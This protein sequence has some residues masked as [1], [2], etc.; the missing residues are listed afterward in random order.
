MRRVR[1]FE[2]YRLRAVLILVALSVPACRGQV[3][4]VLDQANASAWTGGATNIALANTVSQTFVP[5]LS[6]LIAV[7]VGLKTGN[8]GQGGD[9]VTLQILNSAGVELISTSDDL[10]EGYEGFRR[11]NLAGGGTQ[12][13][14]SVTPG[15]SLTI[16]LQDTGKGVFVWKYNSGNTYPPGQA[17][18]HGSPFQNNDFLF[19]TWGA[20]FCPG[21]DQANA[22]AWTG[23]ATNIAPANTVSQ[24]FVPSL[25][26]LMEVEA[27]LKT[28]NSGQ[29]GDRV[30]LQILNSSGEV[31]ST[32]SDNIPEGYEG[33]W[34][35]RVR[36]SWEAPDGITITPSQPLT[37]RLQDTGKNVFWW[38][39]NSGNTYPAGQA[40][41]HGSPFQDND[42]LFKTYGA[43]TCP[44][45]GGAAGQ[46]SMKCSV[47]TN[48]AAVG[49]HPWSGRVR[50]YSG[51][52]AMTIGQQIA[53]AQMRASALQWITRCHLSEPE[54][55]VPYCPQSS[56]LSCDNIGSSTNDSNLFDG[57]HCLAGEGKVGCGWGVHCPKPACP[58]GVHCAEPVGSLSCLAVKNAQGSDGRWWR[59]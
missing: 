27:G 37:V 36:R 8:S 53:L 42:F 50:P 33:F 32:A 22:P 13:G 48:E 10:P 31:L 52:T 17:Y 18:F 26:C 15:Q 56:N 12:N 9:R 41:F 57:L 14:L 4:S 11:F 54:W 45:G 38:K 35:F 59:S 1:F 2:T 19:K 23:G 29:G 28:G 40:Y 58:T 49:I 25:P 30:T 34:R 16:R 47:R 55:N 51:Y 39:Y 24:T 44:P 3:W 21:Q 7:E 5:S 46:A 20:T 43:A 6:C